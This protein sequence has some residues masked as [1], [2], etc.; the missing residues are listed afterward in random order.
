MGDCWSNYDVPFYCLDYKRRAGCPRWNKMSRYCLQRG[1]LFEEFRV[2][3]DLG[4]KR[5]T[6]YVP[7]LMHK[8]LLLFIQNISTILIG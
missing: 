2:W 5:R 1:K 7:N 8:L 4:F 6:F 3:R